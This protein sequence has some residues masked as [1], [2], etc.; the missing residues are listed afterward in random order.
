MVPSL[1]R[2]IFNSFAKRFFKCGNVK[3]GTISGTNQRQ[4]ALERMKKLPRGQLNEV[5]ETKDITNDNL[6]GYEITA[7]GKTQDGKP[8]LVYEVM[9]FNDQGDYFLILG[10]AKENFEDNLENFRKIAKTFKRK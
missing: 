8:Q 10:N 3:F 1:G 2:F 7:D 4:Y 9:L 5:K 6:K